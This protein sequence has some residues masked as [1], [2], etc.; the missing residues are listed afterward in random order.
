[1]SKI[2]KII[3]AL[4][5]DKIPGMAGHGAIMKNK[6]LYFMAELHPCT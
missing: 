5:Y 2:G 3:I 4:M 1:M 6:Y